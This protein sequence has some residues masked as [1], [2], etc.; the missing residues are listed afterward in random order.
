[1]TGRELSP[2]YQPALIN[3]PQEELE[4]A[5]PETAD[6]IELEVFEWLKGTK[7]ASTSLE[8]L[9]GG[10]ANFIYRAQLSTPLGDGTTNVLV[11]H[12]EGYMAVAPTNKISTDRC[13]CA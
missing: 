3:K 1:V 4:I 11:K 9:S 8:P 6:E 10:N 2:I 12:G 7:Y 5:A 13:V